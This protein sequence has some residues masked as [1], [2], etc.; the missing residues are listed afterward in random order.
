MRVPNI[1]VLRTAVLL[2]SLTLWVN[3]AHAQVADNPKFGEEISKQSSIYQ[4]QGQDVP[5]GYVTGRSL[6]SYEFTLPAEFNRSL[7][8]LGPDDRWLDIG[9]GEG[10]AVL[11]YVNSKYDVLH[12]KAHE[13]NGKKAK[14]VAISIEDRRTSYWHQTAAK[15]GPNQIQYFF[16]KTFRD[17]SFEELGKF[18][19]ITDLL[20]AFSYTRDVSTFMEKALG[21]LELNGSLYTVLQDVHSEEGTNQPHYPNSPYLTEITRGDGS[22]VKMCSWLKSISC[23]QVTCELKG[24]WTPPIEVYRI[25]KVCDDVRVPGLTPTHFQAGTPPE[26]RFQLTQPLPA[27]VAGNPKA[28]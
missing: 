6:L 21:F 20:G 8:N 12:S 9:A 26:R 3:A 1:T 19:V 2:S 23:V 17:Y 15:L 16:G 25:H 11:D 14:A 7:S 13:G 22:E 27:S 18:K 4:S 24:D 28:D 5:E 10:R